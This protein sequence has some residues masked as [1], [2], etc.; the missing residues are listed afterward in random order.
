MN[1]ALERR[2]RRLEASG[3]TNA[4]GLDGITDEE[5]IAILREEEPGPDT[6]ALVTWFQTGEAPI[7]F[8]LAGYSK[9]GHDPQLARM[10]DARLMRIA[11][12]GSL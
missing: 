7:G 12:G 3:A 1:T 10:S 5:L 6:E 2:L 11:R 8:D 9:R 4:A